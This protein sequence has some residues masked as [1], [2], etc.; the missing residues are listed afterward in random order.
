MTDGLLSVT[1]AQSA[2]PLNIIFCLNH[3]M[4]GHIAGTEV[5]TAALAKS[6]QQKGHAVSVVI[7]NYKSEVLNTYQY[8]EITVYQYPEPDKKDR[9]VIM[10]KRAP[11]GIGAFK[12]LIKKL[13][14]DIVHVQELAGSSGIGMYHLRT[15]NELGVKTVFTMHLAHYSCFCGTLMYKGKEH[16]NGMIN[17][18]KCTRCALNKLP[19][20]TV[21]QEILYNV[22][23]PLYML[24]IDTGKLNTSAGTAFSY[25][26]II[27]KKRS[28]LNEL[29]SLCDKIIV[30]TDWYKKVL[31]QN[32][33]A[34]NKLELVKQALPY[35]ISNPKSD[36][37]IEAKTI[38]LVFIGRID[39]LKGLHLLLEAMQDLQEEKIYLDIFGSITDENYYN[40][41]KQNSSEKKNICWKGLL[42]QKDV[43]STIQQYHALVLPSVFS[44]MSPLVI[45]EAF[46]AGVPVI[47]SD[48]AGIAE[49]IKHN[50]N[51]LLFEFNDAAS[52][53]NTILSLIKNPLLVSDLKGNITY[54]AAF[55]TVADQMEE[56]YADVLTTELPFKTKHLTS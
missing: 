49:Q 35:K 30:L 8:E 16:C 28:A 18:K 45:Q 37:A 36:N 39:P 27:D 53:K 56:I 6:L 2:Y 46:A 54:P 29:V 9:L 33:I 50:Y 32:G 3:F 55:E 11:E 1:I 52:L 48:V 41:W 13:Q 51:G 26:F 19:I 5:Y 17:I 20:N 23:M 43:V 42:P 25:P 40:E 47:G 22:S 38:R 24:N 31:L 7:P 34:E 10:G 12:K 21:T 44:E 4:P 14:P 15:L